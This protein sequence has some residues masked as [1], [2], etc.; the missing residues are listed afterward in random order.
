VGPVLV[1]A[2]ALV[3][4]LVS[5]TLAALIGRGIRVADTAREEPVGVPAGWQS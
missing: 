2:I 5:A 4:F 3:W 1:A